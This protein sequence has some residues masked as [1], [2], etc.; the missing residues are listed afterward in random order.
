MLG[1]SQAQKY[2]RATDFSD[3]ELANVGGRS[4]VRT[5]AVDS[6]LD[7]IG[8]SLNRAIVNQILNQRDDGEI[9]DGRVKLFTL[10]S[11]VLALLTQY[12]SIPRGAWLTNTLY[13]PKDLVAQSGNTYISVTLHTSGVFAT[14]LAAGKWLLFS[15]SATPSA[16]AVTFTPTTNLASTTVQAAIE[17]ADTEGRALS[18][19]LVAGLT[20][21]LA[22]AVT[23]TKGA[24]QIGFLYSLGYAAGTV[25]R[26]LQDLATSVGSSFIGFIQ[27]GIGAVLLSLQ[28]LLRAQKLTPKQFGAAGDGVTLDDAP[29][30]AMLAAAKLAGRSVD[31]QDRPYAI[32]AP[33]SLSGFTSF[34]I[35]SSGASLVGP[36]SGTLTCLLDVRNPSDI[37]LHGRLG[38]VGSYNTSLACGVW[39]HAD[40]SSPTAQFVEL[41]GLA[42]SGC[43]LAYRIG[44]TA[45]PD[46]IV[47]EINVFGGYTYGCPSVIQAEGAQTVVNFIGSTIDSD[48]GAGA[49]PW[50]ALTQTT[51]RALGANVRITGGEINHASNALGAAMD[52]QPVTSAAASNPYGSISCTNVAIESAAQLATASNPGAISSPT[53]GSIKLIACTGFHSADSFAF[54]QTV[55]SYLGEVVLNACNFYA[56]VTRTQANISCA[57]N[58][59]NVYCDEQSFGTNFLTQ[60]RGISGGTPHYRNKLILSCSTPNN[61]ISSGVMTIV[62]FQSSLAFDD[63]FRYSAGYSTSTGRFTVP[64]GGLKDVNVNVG[65]SAGAATP[66]DVFVFLN[67]VVT[68][69]GMSVTGAQSF[70]CYFKSLAAGDIVDVRAQPNGAGITPTASSINHMKIMASN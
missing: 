25:G 7:S 1:M 39:L 59:T 40:A 47:S 20:T 24:G 16:T 21:D 18:A 5:A 23:L 3:E 28:T 53:G 29:I 63:S 67:G 19:S 4:T 61:S 42:F 54:I 48:Y 60:L 50:L 56:S 68:D 38:I 66:T 26:W 33:V 36:T 27:T 62:V 17:E 37:T 57:A 34:N 31:F 51:V 44:D 41:R 52:V 49:A 64:V 6:E 2:V 35:H 11:D 9:R 70:N 30:A 65:F 55:A 8:V 12:G 45:F 58:A 15:L 69:S 32:S 46:K 43:K 22:N 10:A 14:D 13:S